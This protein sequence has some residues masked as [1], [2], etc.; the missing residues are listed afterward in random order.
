MPLPRSLW[1]NRAGSLLAVFLSCYSILAAD[2]KFNDSDRARLS[3]D[4]SPLESGW[5]P[6]TVTSVIQSQ[7][8]YLWLGTY[9]GLVRFDGVRLAIFD[10][11]NTS[12]LRNNRITSLHEDP[13][14]VIWIGH[15][16]GELTRFDKGSFQPVT[17]SRPWPGG[18]IEAITID[19][20]N[21]L[22][23]ANDRGILFRL[24]D[25]LT[26]ESPGSGSAARK[27]LVTRSTT[28]Q[29]WLAAAGQVATLE[30][31]KT[32]PF[33]FNGGNEA[34]FYQAVLPS[35]KGGLWVIVNGEV[36][37]FKEGRWELPLKD[38]PGPQSPVTCLL[39]TRSGALLAGTLNDGLHLFAPGAAPIHFNRTNGLSHDW[40]RCLCEDHEGNVWIGTGAGLDTL[41]A[42]K[43]KMLNAPDSWQDRAVLSFAAHADG[44]AW[45]GT[46]GAGL[47]RYQDGKWTTFTE[48]SGLAN[49]FVW[50]VLE[51]R[52]GQLFVGTWGGGL[53]L[54]N[55]DRF[56]SQGELG[57]INAPIV[58][59]FEGSKGEVWIGTTI[60][61]YRYE[62]GHV[63][64]FAGKEK[65]FLPDI[66]AITESPDG[67]LWFGMVG[68]GV[69]CLREGKLSQYTTKD[70]LTSDFVQSLYAEPDGT[71]WIGTSD[72]GLGRWQKG[73]FATIG[74]DQGLPNGI[75]SHVVDDGAGNL[76]MG[77]HRGILRA[78]KA[79][80][81]RC[82]NG[83][84]RSIHCLSYGKAEGLETESCSGGFQPG[85]CRT[86]DG[87]LWFPT[88]KGLAI[89]D[90][91]NVTTN[92]VEPPVVIE[93]LL[94]DGHLIK[95]PIV[96]NTRPNSAGATLQI[97]RGNQRFE[98]HYA[99]LSFAA[100]EKVL[101]RYKLE[102]LERLWMDAGT[103]RVAEYSYLPPG[104]Y[105]FHVIACNNDEVWNE[106]GAS[107]SFTVLPWFYQTWWFRLAA[108]VGGAAA[109]GATV[110]FVTRRRVRDRLEQLERQQAVERERARIAR[111]IH[112]DLGASLTRIT[113]LSQTV[114][115]ELD[116]RQQA[117]ADIDQIYGTARELTRAM[118]EIVWA[119]NPKHDT[120]DSLVT[121]LGRFAQTFLGTAGIRCRLEVPL[122]LLAWTV[123]AEIRH[124]V[125][126]AFKEALNNAV[127]HAG[128][129]EV[130]ISLEVRP[131]GLLLLVADNGSGFEINGFENSL[132]IHPDSTRLATGNGL[133][134]MRKRLDEIGGRC[135][136]DTARGE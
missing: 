28:S 115:G 59:M 117:A 97:P 17:F 38:R 74:P 107:L 23:L 127:K 5:Q 111:D 91:I 77:S 49:L 75:I 51:T 86:P 6:N 84:T 85:A 88:A 104:A 44:S 82:A 114:R 89:I 11:S 3:F 21:D 136:W 118:D 31:G 24:R 25:G 126:L 103:R 18:A 101:F 47:Y 39:E 130:R 116:D 78:S 2:A 9:N 22:W 65:L 15:E 102:G 69:G 131:S 100:P 92:R 34:D 121:Y 40:V 63:T 50:S 52:A 37:R 56:E 14:G 110:V 60:G 120:V 71:L 42:R 62:V 27:V 30:R 76:W 1:M 80:L 72:K 7:D 133:L 41:R 109:V 10:S 128:A 134:N 20:K 8:G 13:Q 94:V 123:T 33:K 79:D 32:V 124:N 129:S 125:F 105:T 132:A 83:D 48:A 36:R 43:V 81:N 58:S 55:G 70:G 99:G 96:P 135:E 61:L 19:E 108:I 46:E 54:K 122:Q 73:K 68:G 64:W 93:G 35:R 53:L 113:M 12:G 98:I 26:A 57:K 66:R 87:L 45:V 4:I 16:T 95:R 90:P 29:I 106:T 112:D 119:V 67:A